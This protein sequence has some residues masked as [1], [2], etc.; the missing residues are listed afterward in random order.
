MKDDGEVFPLS[1]CTVCG[2]TPSNHHPR[3]CPNS[4]PGKVEQGEEPVATASAPQDKL[5]R[6]LALLTG[7]ITQQQSIQDKENCGVYY[8][9]DEEYE[10]E[11]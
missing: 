2:A 11:E 3:C 4:K 8:G 6:L 9:E 10:E 5:D 1:L 7:F